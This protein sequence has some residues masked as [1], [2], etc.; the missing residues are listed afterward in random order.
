MRAVQDA[1][2]VRVRKQDLRCV[3]AKEGLSLRIRIFSAWERHPA[4]FSRLPLPC[5]Y[6]SLKMLAKRETASGAGGSTRALRSKAS[7]FGKSPGKAGGR[8]LP[9]RD[10]RAE[11]KAPLLIPSLTPPNPHADAKGAPLFVPDSSRAFLIRSRQ[12]TSRQ[13]AS[14]LRLAR[15]MRRC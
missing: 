9:P 1:D 3:S 14:A 5:V 7:P 13:C 6:V 15:S 8:A 10:S 2:Q 12:C 4:Y 11:R